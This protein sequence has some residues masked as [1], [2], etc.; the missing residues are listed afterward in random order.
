[1][2]QFARKSPKL[3]IQKI[4]IVTNGIPTHIYITKEKN[5]YLILSLKADLN[6]MKQKI[7]AICGS[8]RKDSSNLRIIQTIAGLSS[9]I[10]E[11]EIFKGLHLLPHFNPDLDT[12][13]PPDIVLQFRN[14]L[15]AADA[16]LI[17]TPEYVFSLPGSLKNALEWT[18]STTIFSGKPVAIITASGLGEKAHES[19]QLIMKTLEAKMNNSTQLLISA[20]RASLNHAGEITDEH[21]L[22]KIQ[23]LITALQELIPAGSNS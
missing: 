8:T 12:D 22:L 4:G 11:M 20:A 7:L 23:E 17:C 5:V 9:D 16:V 21:L 1:M 2:L 13:L 18:V 10:F 15:I 6:N 19:L 14:Q 3:I